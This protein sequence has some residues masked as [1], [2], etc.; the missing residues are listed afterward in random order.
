VNF[1]LDETYLIEKMEVVQAF[2]PLPSEVRSV[3]YKVNSI[4]NAM[5][6]SFFSEN[7]KEYCKVGKVMYSGKD[8]RGSEG[9]EKFMR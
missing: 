9:L 4:R 5:A 1:I 2:K 6:H 7:R 8:I 3:I